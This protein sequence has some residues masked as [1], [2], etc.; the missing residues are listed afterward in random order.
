MPSF[1]QAFNSA[2]NVATSTFKASTD[3]AK[4][5]RQMQ[6]AAQEGNIA[7]IKRSAEKLND[8]LGTVRQEV[9]NAIGAW[10]F[11]DEGSSSTR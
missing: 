8:A 9:G 1:E 11:R 2:E 6:K 7:A 5:A 10:P 4:L 3:L